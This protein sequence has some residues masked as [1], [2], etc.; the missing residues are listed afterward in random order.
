MNVIGPPL[1]V[2]RHTCNLDPPVPQPV[3]LATTATGVSHVERGV[4]EA[5]AART[6]PAPV[7]VRD[8]SH[9][10]AA[11]GGATL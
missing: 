6:G 8:G 1:P 2:S 9:P 3:Q 4:T 10:H 7:S 5:R 11:V